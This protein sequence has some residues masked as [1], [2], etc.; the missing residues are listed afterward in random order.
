M[1]EVIDHEARS[2]AAL[3]HQRISDHE[4]ACAE[5]WAQTYNAISRLMALLIGTLLATIGTLVMM[6]YDRLQ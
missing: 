5:R 4:K 6:L 3:A 2:E 1:T